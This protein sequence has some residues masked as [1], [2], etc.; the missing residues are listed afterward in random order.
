MS[1]LYVCLYLL[2]D[3]AGSSASAIKGREDVLARKVAE[4]GVQQELVHL[5]Q[6]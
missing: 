2:S 4:R 6:G 1:A 3:G 5:Y